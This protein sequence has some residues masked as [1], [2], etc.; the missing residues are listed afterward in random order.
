MPST[1]IRWTLASTA[2]AALISGVVACSADT[3]ETRSAPTSA[4]SSSSAA[5]AHEA[6]NQCMT[7]NGVPAPPQG[8]PGGPGADGGPPAGEP[9][10]GPPPSGTSGD[11]RR[12]P[13]PPGVDQ[14]TWDKAMQACA[15]LAPAQP[16]H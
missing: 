7:D 6:F 11:G 3:S 12:P 10:A 2:A 1:I 5:D 16:Q 14:D 4:A 9:P 15:S 8:G 13:S